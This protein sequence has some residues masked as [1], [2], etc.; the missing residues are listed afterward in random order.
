MDSLACFLLFAL[1]IWV[2]AERGEGMGHHWRDRE[3]GLPRP[4]TSNQAPAGCHN[5]CAGQLAA[6][7]EN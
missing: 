6:L 2:E 1:E 5:S 4:P 3:M 7:T